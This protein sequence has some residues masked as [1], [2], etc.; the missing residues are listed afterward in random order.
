M[1]S[2]KFK[3]ESWDELCP[4]FLEDNE[5]FIQI[6]TGVLINM[7]DKTYLLTAA[8]I[9]DELYKTES[10]KLLVPS[11]NGF[12]YI[13]GTLYHRHLKEN[14]NRDDD[15]INFS[16]YELSNDM[17]DLLHEYLIPLNEN[18]IELKEKFVSEI[19]I[20]TNLPKA[21]DMSKFLRGI[22]NNNI[23][24]SDDSISE[25]KNFLYDQIITFAGYHIQKQKVK[26]I[27]ILQKLLI[28]MVI[29]YLMQYIRILIMILQHKLLLNM[30][31]KEL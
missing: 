8:H 29:Q 10:A 25:F 30:V 20:L 31:K 23:K 1:I 6:G 11:T 24:I 27:Y 12:E 26:E 4:I 3:D 22:E 13:M 28:T 14:E 9:I 5:V 15:K 2:M 16:F 17:I 18:M 7:F 19:E 21:K